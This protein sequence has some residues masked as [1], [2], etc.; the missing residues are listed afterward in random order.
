MVIHGDRS[1]SISVPTTLFS[2]NVTYYRSPVYK[3]TARFLVL[4]FTISRLNCA[5][6]GQTHAPFGKWSC[7]LK[8]YLCLSDYGMSPQ[9][10]QRGYPL[11]FGTAWVPAFQWSVLITW[12][13]HN[14]VMTLLAH[15]R[16]MSE[17]HWRGHSLSFAC[18]CSNW[19]MGTNIITLCSLGVDDNTWYH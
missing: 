14:R 19:H 17:L 11:S 2:V 12:C 5:L 3:S 1:N 9:C 8:Q 4:S 10:K 16:L 6:W 15:V 18:H 7:Q 13:Y